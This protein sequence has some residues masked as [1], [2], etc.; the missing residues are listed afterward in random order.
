MFPRRQCFPGGCRS[1]TGSDRHGRRRLRPS[2]A[3][4]RRARWRRQ[5]RP[6]ISRE[7]PLSFRALKTRPFAPLLCEHS[8]A[9]TF[10]GAPMKR[11]T[12]A[13]ASLA[14]LVAAI[15]G[16]QGTQS[17]ASR[18]F[19]PVTDAMLAKPDPGDWLMWRRTLDSWGYS[20]LD[21]INRGNVAQLK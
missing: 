11:L 16:A 7:D 3:A 4:L 12:F 17:V 1:P 10:R 6:A 13:I 2:A 18:P 21:Q 9:D 8:R 14:V 19:T 15:V 20:P 5:V